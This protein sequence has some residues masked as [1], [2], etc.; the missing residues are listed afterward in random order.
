MDAQHLKALL[1]A[2]EGV[3]T[4]RAAVAAGVSSAE[5]GQAL[6]GGVL[7]RVRPGLY[8]DAL[9]WH[10]APP[11]ER[12]TRT[13]G[14]VLATNSRWVASHHAALAVH[15]LPLVEVDFTVVDVAAAVR[16]SK[17]RPGIHVHRLAPEH[18]KLPDARPRVLPVAHAC[19]LTAAASGVVS[20]VCAMDAALHRSLCTRADLEAALTHPGVR[21]GALRARTAV[22]G[23]DG[24]SESPGESRTRLALGSLGVEVLSQVE[25][26]DREGFI[27]R[28]DLLVEGLVVVEFD[29]AT[30]YAG[31]DGRE[32]LM[33]EKRREER[34]RDAGYR[35]V[36]VTWSDLA[37]PAR[38][39]R[40]V[41]EALALAG[42]A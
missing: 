18:T 13:V 32:A 9:G 33:H 35:V 28:V 8:V 41:R 24:L 34:L 36:R 15:G 12:F 21:Y 2:H 1:A 30:K 40:R 31:A 17:V 11:W 14:A 26:R 16:T 5:L 25:L 22:A 23:A 10:D 38:L 29:G 20:G 3:L 7:H 39:L 42:A 19:V 37:D 6:S 4:R 27:G